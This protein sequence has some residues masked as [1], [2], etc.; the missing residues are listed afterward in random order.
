MDKEKR[1]RLEE[2]GWKVGSAADF[3]GLSAED[4]TYIEL[5]L[6]LADA[7]R[8]RRKAKISQI[9][10]AKAIG[11]SQSR[12]AKME[13]NDPSVSL[14]LIIKGLVSLGTT[15]PDLGK[16]I[17]AKYAV[18]STAKSTTAYKAARKK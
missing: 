11:S 9:E 7:F 5:R 6:R 12:V 15:L 2:K 1:K 8:E 14:D 18:A 3:L 10:F 16:I 4:N 17:T 13:A